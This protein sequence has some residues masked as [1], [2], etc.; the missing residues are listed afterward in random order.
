MLN[1][2]N[3]EKGFATSLVAILVLGIMFSI[4]ISVSSVVFGGEKILQNV[5]KSSQSYYIAE[6]GVEDAL[7][8]LKQAPSSSAF[9]YN[10]SAASGSV[11]VTVGDIMGGSRVISTQGDISNRIK[12]IK[13]VYE[14][15][16]ENISFY[17][18]VQVDNGGMVLGNNARVRGNV[19]SNGS[20]ISSNGGR[21]DNDVIVA[22]DGNKI[23][24]L[25]VGGDAL[26]YSCENST[27]TGDLT[28]VNGGSASGCSASSITSQSDSISPESLPIPQDQ[29]DDWKTEAYNGG[30]ITNDYL[31]TN[32]AAA[33][34]GPVQI[35]TDSAPKNLTVSNGATL[36]ITGTVY[37]TGNISLSSNATIK[38][39]PA[40][41]SLSGV[42][43][44]KGE[45]SVGNNGNIQGSGQSG[46][47]ILVLSTSSSINPASP[48]I[49]VSNNAT[50]AIFYAGFGLV[51][52]NNNMVAR[53]VTAYKISLSNNA[54]VQYESGLQNPIFSNG[55]GGSWNIKSWN[56]SE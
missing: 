18:G 41:G 49:A 26:V 40:Y 12:K 27:I 36:K 14:I 33:S 15:G 42:L 21:V 19:F 5:V 39:D 45:I 22:G 20:I 2:R 29:I 37:V 51:T 16:A 56:E 17:Y 4:I 31:L 23:D 55:P 13:A 53:E 44:A 38:L 11:N 47:Y 50:G 28:Y 52:L 30:V 46:S 9:S 34:L 35:G 7:L 43:I 10:F 48:A 24:G 8:R 3:K 1:P 32:N 25:L 6:A 54:E